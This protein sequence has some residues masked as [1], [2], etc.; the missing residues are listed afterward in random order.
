M[1]LIVF[2][3]NILHF[4]VTIFSDLN[5][6]IINIYQFAYEKKTLRGHFTLPKTQVFNVN[7]MRVIFY[8]SRFHFLLL[9]DLRLAFDS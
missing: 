5:L 3:Y 8:T 9:N 2:Q 4:I 7:P 6:N 1:S